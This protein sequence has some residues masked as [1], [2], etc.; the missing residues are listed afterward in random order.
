MQK[1]ISAKSLSA[2][3]HIIL[4]EVHERDQHTDFALLM[5]KKLLNTVSEAVKVSRALMPAPLSIVVIGDACRV[6]MLPTT[7]SIVHDASGV[8][9]TKL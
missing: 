1:I 9:R 8:L 5:V 2:Y 6:S 4:D 3:T 7:I